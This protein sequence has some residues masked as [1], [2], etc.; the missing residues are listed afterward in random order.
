MNR[1]RNRER[2]FVDDDDRGR[3]LG[4]L[5]CYQG[6]A[7]HPPL[8][9]LLKCFQLLSCLGATGSP[10]GSVEV[11]GRHLAPACTTSAGACGFVGHLWLGSFK[12]SAIQCEDEQIPKTFS[13]SMRV[14]RFLVNACVSALSCCVKRFQVGGALRWRPTPGSAAVPRHCLACVYDDLPPPIRQPPA[15]ETPLL[16]YAPS[17]NCCSLNFFFCSSF[18]ILL[19]ISFFFLIFTYV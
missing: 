10:R 13:C 3:F 4:L 17:S 12:S 16:H 14:S 18:S 7:R 11:L 15:V 1:G 5:A 2:I 8:S 9:L 19:S 6:A